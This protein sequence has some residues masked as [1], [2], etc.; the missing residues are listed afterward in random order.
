MA[1]VTTQDQTQCSVQVLR[2]K[3][4]EPQ[5]NQVFID[6]RTAGEYKSSRIDGVESV[7][8]SDIDKHSQRLGQFQEIYVSC[9]NGMR[10]KQAVQKLKAKGLNAIHVDG[11]VVAWRKAGFPV[12][13]GKG[14]AIPVMRQ[15]QLIFGTLILMGLILSQWVHPAFIG[16]TIFS[17]VA[18][19]IGGSTG[20]CGFVMVLDKL[21]WNRA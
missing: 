13:Q 17:G 20:W 8:L 6:V 9:H 19:L 1:S 4:I 14:G 5:P 21:P 11:G 7:P 2:D 3:L 15:V 18:Q 16:L 10:T 12:A